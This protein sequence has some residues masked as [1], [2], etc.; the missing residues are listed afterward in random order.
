M[1]VAKDYGS[2]LGGSRQ[3]SQHLEVVAPTLRREWDN[4]VEVIRLRFTSEDFREK[5]PRVLQLFTILALDI[6][7]RLDILEHSLLQI[8]V[9]LSNYQIIGINV[10]DRGN[11]I[12]YLP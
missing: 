8:Y 5:G 9:D 6:G 4:D 3:L 12:T 11:Q 1:T 2:S 7:F 10:R